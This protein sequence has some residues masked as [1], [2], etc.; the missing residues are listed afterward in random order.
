ML[1]TLFQALAFW[2]VMR[3]CGLRFSFWIGAAVYL[4]VH[5]GTAVPNAPANVGSYQ[6]FT[7][8]GLA[9]FGVDKA[10][11]TA[12]SLV[13]FALLTLPLLLLGFVA[14]SASGTSFGKLR[15]EV[16]QLAKD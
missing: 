7:V 9:L 12:F 1:L 14:I 16:Q 4:I 15:Q 13:V 6:F 5:L 3:G 2:L 8:V 10:T 11:A